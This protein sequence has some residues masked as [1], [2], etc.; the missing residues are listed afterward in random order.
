MAIEYIHECDGKDLQSFARMIQLSGVKLDMKSNHDHM[1]ILNSFISN[2]KRF[3]IKTVEKTAFSKYKVEIWTKDMSQ[4]LNTLIDKTY[5]INTTLKLKIKIKRLNDFSSLSTLKVNFDQLYLSEFN[6]AIY[7]CTEKDLEARKL[8]LDEMNKFYAKSD[9]L[10]ETFM[11]NE[12]A[13]YL[14]DGDWYRVQIKEVEKSSKVK[15]FFVDYGYDDSIET[16]NKDAKCRL[17]PLMDKFFIHASLSFGG[18]L[19]NPIQP[20]STIDI[21]DEYGDV[22][23]QFLSESLEVRIKSQ[24][25]ENG[26]F[27]VELY[28]AKKEFLNQMLIDEADALNKR[29]LEPVKK[30]RPQLLKLKIDELPK[31]QKKFKNEKFTSFVNR[32]DFFYIFILINVDEIQKNVQETCLRILDEQTE[33]DAEQIKKELVQSPPQKDD[34]VYGKYY[35]D[36]AWY[37]CVITNCDHA[38]NKYEIFFIDFG[39]VEIVNREDLLYGWKYEHNDVLLKYEPQAYKC[40]LYGLEPFSKEY[41]PDQNAVFK[42]LVLDKCVIPKLIKINTENI[43]ELS[44]KIVN[45]KEDFVNSSAHYYLIQHKIG[46]CFFIKFIC[47]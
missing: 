34:I 1:E 21:L 29:K 5:K 38:N 37:R 30:L 8:L 23:E 3:I 18:K 2:N 26:I 24:L 25:D 20:M 13:A 19:I 22:F 12:Y 27:G 9:Q 35:D 15:L 17:K 40:K 41:S 47:L 32:I 14:S 10:M 4:C 45:E 11:P 6:E 39:N 31:Q 42:Q 44:L 28:N 7:F 43:Y 36:Q 16:N 33:F 46:I